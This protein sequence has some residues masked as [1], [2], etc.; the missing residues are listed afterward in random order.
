[1]FRRASLASVA[2]RLGAG[3]ALLLA[4][5][6]GERLMAAVRGFD[7][8]A[9]PGDGFVELTFCL[10]TG[11]IDVTPELASKARLPSD[12]PIAY[13]PEHVQPHDVVNASLL[14][15]GLA[16]ALG[17]T[18]HPAGGPA[19]DDMWIDPVAS[20]FTTYLLP[21]EEMLKLVSPHLPDAEATEIPLAEYGIGGDGPITIEYGGLMSYEP[22]MPP[23]ALRDPGAT[24]ECA[25]FVTHDTLP[26]D[27]E[28]LRRAGEVALAIAAGTGGVP[29]DI[30]GFLIERPEDVHL[31]L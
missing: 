27:P 28:L 25:I 10:L 30:N 12:L 22:T 16:R 6:P 18:R 24:F 9:E 5:D 23:P 1:M 31:D 13:L 17:G 20:V 15:S 11:P 7:P 2:K 8:Q 14:V 19:P 3:P 21:R 26:I 4:K 29:L